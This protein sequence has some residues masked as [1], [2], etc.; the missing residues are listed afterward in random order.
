MLAPHPDLPAQRV[1][2]AVRHEWD[3]EVSTAE[4]VSVG[5]RG[6]H[7]ALG[8][9]GG[10]QW[11]ATVDLVRTSDERRTRLASF[12]SAVEVARRVSF[13]V[14]PVHTR[15]ARVAVDLAPGLL[16]SVTPY[17]EG[18]TG[19]A[20]AY[21]DDGERAVVARM[22]GELHRLPRPRWLP[23]WR[24]SIGPPASSRREDLER[25]LETETWAGGP[26]S[27][28]GRPAGARRATGALEVAAT[29]R[30]ALGGRDRQRR[31]LGAHP[32]RRRTARTWC[33]DPTGPG[34]STGARR[35]WRHVSATSA[36][37]SAAPRGTTRGTPTSKGGGRPDPLSPDTVELFALQRHLS[38]IAEHAVQFSRPHHDTAD[39]RHA[40]RRARGGA[41]RA[42]RAMDV[43]VARRH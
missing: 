10:R 27:V 38:L 34:S 42:G 20:G 23:L 41:D 39:D 40:L 31:P 2:A 22:L 43:R 24:P 12:E 15:D 16:L 7:W 26:W 21:A 11:L 8:D 6:W 14:A 3:V 9:D 19:G 30:P 13:A 35:H 32:R 18:T 5:A 25:C 4:H 29:L 1:G 37:S 28:P 33:T 17:L 36:R